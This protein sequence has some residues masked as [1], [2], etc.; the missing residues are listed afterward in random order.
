M[1]DSFEKLAM[2]R[3]ERQLEKSSRVLDIGCSSGGLFSPLFAKHIADRSILY[4]GIDPDKYKLGLLRQAWKDPNVRL[5]N[6]DI[7]HFTPISHYDLAV[8]SYT[9][10]HIRDVTNVLDKVRQL[11]KTGGNLLVIDEGTPGLSTHTVEQEP[12][13]PHMEGLRREF[14]TEAR[15][16]QYIRYVHSNSFNIIFRNPDVNEIE[17]DLDQ[18][19]FVI[20]DKLVMNK[21]DKACFMLL[22]RKK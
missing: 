18:H 19:G 5:F 20:D 6:T 13:E 7:E 22:A 10:H 16:Q 8:V 12:L 3:I 21:G 1:V 15:L 2:Q 11:L 17:Q 14:R 9:W 4:H